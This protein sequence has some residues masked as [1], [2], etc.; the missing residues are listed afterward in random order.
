[1]E[2]IN[3]ESEQLLAKT[4]WTQDSLTDTGNSKVFNKNSIVIDKETSKNINE[5]ERVNSTPEPRLET[6]SSSVVVNDPIKQG[7]GAEAYTSYLVTTTKSKGAMTSVRRR[8]SDFVWLHKELLDE[9]P[10]CIIPP[11]PG[12]QQMSMFNIKFIFWQ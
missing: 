11:I 1:M 3:P 2:E 12:K 7:E 4:G 6:L 8:F 5:R 10:T 9:F